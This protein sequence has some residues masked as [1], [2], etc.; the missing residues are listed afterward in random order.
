VGADAGCVVVD[1]V[2][3]YVRVLTRWQEDMLVRLS[4]AQEAEL[5]TEGAVLVTLWHPIWREP[6]EIPHPNLLLGTLRA[7][8]MPPW[9]P[10]ATHLHRLLIVLMP[11]RGRPAQTEEEAA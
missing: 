8:T 6:L 10:A 11:D 5:A 3:Q 2:P 7:D 9:D 4:V 1:A